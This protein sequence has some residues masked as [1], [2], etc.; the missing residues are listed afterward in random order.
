MKWQIDARHRLLPNL[1]CYPVS[2]VRNS[3]ITTK[4]NLLE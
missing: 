2:D 1:K 3:K 4:K